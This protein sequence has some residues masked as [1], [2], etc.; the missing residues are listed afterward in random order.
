MSTGT[1]PSSQVQRIAPAAPA[2]ELLESKL[3]PPTVRGGVRRDELIGVLETSRSVPVVVLSAGPGWGKT[4]LLGQWAARSPRPFAWVTVDEDDNDPIVL[5][6]YV[7]A[8]LD[9][10]SPIDPG[11]YDALAARGASLQG[12]V[13]PRLGAAL[14]KG[15]WPIILALD[16]LHALHDQVC[17]DAIATLVA[18]VP[19]GSQM[20]LSTRGE[21]AVPLAALRAHGL[22][23]EAGADD[24]RMDET[25][26]RHLLA[27]A[28]LK[29]P[30]AD[31]AELTDRT[32][33]WAAG[34]YLA[35]LTAQ[36][37]PP[38][39]AETPRLSVTNRLVS[40][41][42]RSEL[43]A[44]VP[45]D[46]LRFLTRTAMLE[47]LSGP[48]CDAA[49]QTT[50]SAEALDSLARSNLF[51]VPL[52]DT[53]E[54]YRY[55]HLFRDMLRQEQ[56]RADP[57]FVPAALGRAAEWSAA[58]MQPETAIGY[59]LEAGDVD[60]VARLVMFWALFTYESGRVATVERWFAWLEEHG[61]L[62]RNAAVAVLG[63]LVATL[64]GRPAQAERWADAAERGTYEEPLPDGSESIDSWRAFLRAMR[65]A[66]GVARMRADAEEAHRTLAH[67]SPYR[68][69]ALLM[70]AVA[71][72]LA[73]DIDQA[74]KLL[75]DVAENGVELSAPEAAGSA[76]AQRAA[77]AIKRDAWVA[78]EELIEHSLRVIAG[79]R[80]EAYPSSAFAYAIAARV[81]LHQGRPEQA[82]DLL[83][84]SQ[85]LRLGLT[86]ALPYHAVQVRLELAHAYLA[87]GDGRSAGAMFGEI[88]QV[89]Q[90]RP[91]I[92][93][94]RAAV[95]ETRS[96]LH[97]S[98]AGTSKASTLT[99]AELRVLPFLATHLSFR[100]IGERMYLSRHT[101]KSH[102]VA[103]YRKL[104]ASSRDGAVSRAQSSGC[105]SSP[106]CHQG[107]AGA[108]RAR[109]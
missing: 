60:L 25:E 86:Y 66:D 108:G 72:W 95:E 73:G 3:R 67:T 21:P 32:E 91:D 70:V 101:V 83:A 42:L 55:H 64:A 30:D 34:L 57:E 56:L 22:T 7:A 6:T 81:A 103:I 28:G 76:L 14:A 39:A 1:R 62:E 11:V 80:M 96:K 88:D 2:F 17:V 105:S 26:A 61:A 4:T 75:A 90:R 38:E 41:Y 58:N 97:A 84:R 19:K 20:V 13:V 89:L 109:V 69:D 31:V 82:H 16:D 106:S 102:S 87:A 18:H 35:A 71:R 36:G 24:L 29:L 27:D 68:C 9:R 52:D 65:C 46:D 5:L 63:S 48:L 107:D 51:L 44:H 100:E 104:N 49:L 50:G 47:R 94:L 43:L 53:G 54:W 10:V 15:D 33:G 23:V 40:E 77:I 78:A 8:A 45:S 74:D 93:T 98:G 59:A 99:E 85:P 79:A 92:G 37:R 12:T